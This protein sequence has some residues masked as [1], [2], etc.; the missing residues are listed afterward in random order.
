M[1]AQRQQP[2]P[3]AERL[4]YPAHAAKDAKTSELRLPR[5][6]HPPRVARDCGR[7][8]D[9]LGAATRQRPL[10]PHPRQFSLTDVA[11]R[12]TLLL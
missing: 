7:W 2:H 4:T 5:P 3:L 11:C 8:R 12:V 6:N 1:P 9:T 10:D